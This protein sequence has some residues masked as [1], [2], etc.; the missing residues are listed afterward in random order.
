MRLAQVLELLLENAAKYAPEG[1][2]VMVADWT[3]GAEV[4]VAVGDDGP[5]V[6]SADRER[7]FEPFVRGE[8]GDR[9]GS[10]VGL[11]AARRLMAGMGGRLWIEDRPGGGS[12]FVAALAA[13]DEA[14]DASEVAPT[15]AVAEASA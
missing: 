1:A 12:Q 11:F 7:V 13:A 4:R 9:P 8:T 14:A 3:D 5:G 2:T 6:P 10:G 15:A